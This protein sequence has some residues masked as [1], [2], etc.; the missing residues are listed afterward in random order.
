M[1]SAAIDLP[2]VS[3]TLMPSSSEYTNVPTTMLRP[4]LH[5][6]RR[7][8]RVHMHGA[9]R[10]GQHAEEVI[11]CLGDRV[12]RPV[13]VDVTYLELLEGAPEPVLARIVDRHQAPSS[14]P[15]PISSAL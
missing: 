11:L 5:L 1:P 8:V 12:A 13:P 4:L 3:G 10:P 15:L 2:D 9:R 14:R 6:G 7:V